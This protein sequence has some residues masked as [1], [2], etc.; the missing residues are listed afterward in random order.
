MYLY[1]AQHLPD[2][3]I[4]PCTFSEENQIG[5]LPSTKIYFNLDIDPVTEFRERLCTSNLA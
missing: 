4:L 3:N 5:A 1:M 2:F